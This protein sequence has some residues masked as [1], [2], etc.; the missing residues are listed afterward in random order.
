MI[1]TIKKLVTDSKGVTFEKF[2]PVLIAGTYNGQEYNFSMDEVLASPNLVQIMEESGYYT[3]FGYSAGDGLLYLFSDSGTNCTSFLPIFR[4]AYAQDNGYTPERVESFTAQLAPRMNNNSEL[5]KILVSSIFKFVEYETQKINVD[6]LNV[7]VGLLD[8]D[9]FADTQEFVKQLNQA[10][11]K[12]FFHMDDS[13]NVTL[14]QKECTDEVF[15]QLPSL[16]QL[17]STEDASDL[18]PTFGSVA[19]PYPPELKCAYTPDYRNLGIIPESMFSEIEGSAENNSLPIQPNEQRFYDAICDWIKYNSKQTFGILPEKDSEIVVDRLTEGYLTELIGNIYSWYWGHNP[20]VPIVKRGLKGEDDSDDNSESASSK[21]EYVQR[22]ASIFLNDSATS[23]PLMINAIMLLTSFVEKAKTIVGYQAY[24]EAIIKLLRWGT[25]KCSGLLITGYNQIF[26][27]GTNDI[28]SYIGSINDYEPSTDADGNVFSIGALVMS[29]TRVSDN[30]WLRTIGAKQN[31]L[32]IPIGVGLDMLMKNKNGDED[33]AIQKYYAMPDFICMIVKGEKIAGVSMDGAGN[34]TAPD[35]KGL[36]IPSIAARDVVEFAS[37]PNKTLLYDPIYTSDAIRDLYLELEVNGTKENHFTLLSTKLGNSN[38]SS[39]MS[40]VFY[41]KEELDEYTKFGSSKKIIS[42]PLGISYRILSMILPIYFGVDIK[43]NPRGDGKDFERLLNLYKDVMLE[44]DYAGEAAFLKFPKVAPVHFRTL[45]PGYKAP[46]IEPEQ[47]KSS[48]TQVEKEI[49][50]SATVRKEEAAPVEAF[51][52]AQQMVSAQQVA[53]EQ[54]TQQL[55][56]VVENKN[57]S[58]I[59]QPEENSVYVKLIASDGSVVGIASAT[60]R[61]VQAGEKQITDFIL[62]PAS[63]M[64]SVQA[65]RF[66]KSINV[67]DVYTNLLVILARIECK[68]IEKINF[69]FNSVKTM[70]YYVSLFKKLAELKML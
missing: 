31:I 10:A 69:F 63:A 20:N 58:L 14:K 17:Q 66:V 70:S 24:A 34:I 15:I 55:E 26:Q 35:V 41:T 16:Y 38:L 28:R 4:G 50:A 21:Y 49:M 48:Y 59:R 32:S 3:R 54:P 67:R 51:T 2:V 12:V 29:D 7:P 65:S 39:N 9:V 8:P 52:S 18:I 37:D 68:E 27:L 42:K 62:L 19:V 22:S 43:F 13:Q 25:R 33:C 40:K 36:G 5:A 57:H 11:V 47:S 53:Q 6:K 56:P 45:V 44:N 46:Q 60:Q 64:D 61:K 23:A 30:G 1:F